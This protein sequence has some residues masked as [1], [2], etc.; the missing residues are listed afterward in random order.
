MEMPKFFKINKKKTMG[1]LRKSIEINPLFYWKNILILMGVVLVISALL[2][3]AVY[4][5]AQKGMLVDAKSRNEV[6]SLV[7]TKFNDT[8]LARLV[9]SF[10]ERS[11]KRQEIINSKIF[12][13]DPTLKTGIKPA[14][15]NPAR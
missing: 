5:M 13:P 1:S 15:Q 7:L 10:E 12:F 6:Q 3:F 8:G 2:S 11:R 9:A 4:Y 14:V